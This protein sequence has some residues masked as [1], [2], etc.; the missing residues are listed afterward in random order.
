MEASLLAWILFLPLAS[1]AA[2]GLLLRRLGSLAGLVSIGTAFAVA[3]LA[4]KTL[5]ALGDGQVVLAQ[6]EIGRLGETAL[7]VGLRLDGHAALMLFVVTFVG[8][9]IHLFSWGY[10]RDDG[11]RKV[12]LGKTSV[13]E[14][15]ASTQDD[16]E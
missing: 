10:M 8:A 12:L 4:L 14:V 2:C 3:G 16:V 11:A 6:A 1:A 5:L 13:E 9:C 7:R 15:L